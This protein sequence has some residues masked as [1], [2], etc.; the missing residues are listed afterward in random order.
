MI[1]LNKTIS[2]LICGAVFSGIAPI[3]PANAAV[4]ELE[5]KEGTIYDAKAFINGMYIYEGYKNENAESGTY[6]STPNGDLL[7]EDVSGTGQRYGMN[8]I[9]FK[10]DDILF[11]LATGQAEEDTEEDKVIELENKFIRKVI[12]K[13][14]RYED[15]EEF[16]IEEKIAEDNFSSIWYEGTAVEE[17]EIGNRKYTVYINDKGEYIDASEVLNVVYYNESGEKV[18]L[19][20]YE[21]MLEYNEEVGD[22]NALNI[23]FEK[24]LMLDAE[25]IYRAF[26]MLD[27][28]KVNHLL[29]DK[30]IQEQYSKIED[31]EKLK[32]GFLVKIGAATV[33]TQKLSMEKGNKKDGAYLP[34]KVE[35][36]EAWDLIP[37]LMDFM[38]DKE[39]HARISGKS[40]FVVEP[41]YDNNKISMYKYKMALVRDKKSF[42][43]TVT[44][45]AIELDEDFD[46]VD[47]EDMKDFCIDTYGNLWIL[48]KG[49]V[50]KL[51]G[52]KLETIYKVDRSMNKLS[53]FDENSMI[54][55]NTDQ[56][57]YSVVNN[58]SVSN[59]QSAADSESEVNKSEQGK[60]ESENELIEGNQSGIN[61][62]WIKNSDGS[63]T[64]KNL[65]G[66]NASGWIKDNDKWYYINNNGIMA[67]GWLNDGGDWYYL[68]PS[69]D[70]KTGWFKD[71]DGSWYYLNQ[72]GKMEYNTI[73]NGYK[74]DAS[75]VWVI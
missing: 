5:V 22:E 6:F 18:K 68:N 61:T 17:N 38:S 53:V 26:V 54:I 50:K 12:N 62:G 64:Y 56:E 74:L 34:K 30:N 42:D 59:E 16:K 63:W 72:S 7:I 21:D 8:Y 4:T 31:D 48:S 23:V 3:T 52:D 71:D 60:E 57:I 41:D 65:D 67:T 45:K 44:R 27:N 2:L 39:V 51:V 73:I 36:Y 11:N 14:D 58:N 9:N 25:N 13:I 32:L 75:G 35:S 33:Y 15:V 43:E 24:T 55:W 49:E 37:V 47:D 1:R 29:T 70:M 28:E 69:G 19:D 20:T 66:T 10:D 46:F 40:I